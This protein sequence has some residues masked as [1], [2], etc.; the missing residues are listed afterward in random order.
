[1]NKTGQKPVLKYQSL[2]R[3]S[4]IAFILFNFTVSAQINCENDTTL[5]KPLVDLQ[6]DFYLGYQGGLYPGGFNE[7]PA[8]HADSGI[9][10][11]QSLL[12][13]NFDG[14]EDTLYG[15]T[16]MLGL[17]SISAGKSF[18]KFISQYNDAGYFD[19]CVHIVNAC[20]DDFGLEQM[21]D[22]DADDTYWKDI[23]DFLQDVDLKKKQVRV[24]W[25]MTTSFEDSITTMPAYIDSLTT[26]YIDLIREL[27][28]QFI[29]LKLIYFSGLQYGGYVDLTAEHSNAFS[30]PAPYYNDFAIKAAIT[31]QLNGDTLLNYSGVDAPAAWVAWGPNF[32][33][34]GR[35]LRDY[36]ELRWLCP[37]DYDVS[38]NGIVL[39]GT[40]TQKIADRL[41]DFFT[42][43]A[44]ATPW[45]FGLPYDCFTEVDI[46]DSV[47]VEI[48]HDEVVYITQ[49]PVKGVIKFII[50]L[51]T[52]EKAS[53]FVF[54][55]LG[56]Q[57]VEGTLSK[58]EPDK[59][60][61][62][63]LTDHPSGVY[64]LSVFVEGKVYNLPFYLSP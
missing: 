8:S 12:P 37:G 49:N 60:F 50:D 39:S 38:N 56:Q 47:I 9:A 5:L 2:K 43:D 53:V 18:N 33:A 7:M 44:T 48:P 32:W 63:K 26:K 40:G 46:E 15:K 28:E 17:G 4:V 57:V 25:V 29:N 31:A 52:N 45:I 59:I 14:E 10:I 54:N 3:I 20:L 27:K 21:I 1:M 22:A 6:S 34:D 30:E 35:N 62:I 11:A 42:T 23:N 19:S 55:A 16:V 61:D 41:F 64:F 58:I 24:V 36:D 51:E 13:I